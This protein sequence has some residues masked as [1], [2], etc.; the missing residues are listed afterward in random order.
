[1]GARSEPTL[2]EVVLR[3]YPAGDLPNSNGNVWLL[4]LVRSNNEL[5]LAKQVTLGLG[6]KDLGAL[7]GKFEL[8]PKGDLFLDGIRFASCLTCWPTPAAC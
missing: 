6:T 1:M 2:P 4:P 5:P 3:I 8:P 7:N